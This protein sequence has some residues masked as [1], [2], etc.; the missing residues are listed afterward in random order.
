[1][2]IH[3]TTRFTQW[4]ALRVLERVGTGAKRIGFH[5]CAV[6]PTLWLGAGRIYAGS[7]RRVVFVCVRVVFVCARVVF[8]ICVC[9]RVRARACVRTCVRAACV[10][11][12]CARACV[13]AYV[14]ACV[15]VCV[16]A[17]VRACVCLCVC[18]ARRGKG[19]PDHEGHHHLF[20]P[21]VNLFHQTLLQK[22]DVG[23]AVLRFVLERNFDCEAA[24][25]RTATIRA[26]RTDFAGSG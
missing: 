9:A 20:V 19:R 13:R 22:G 2:R 16:R 4:R 23:V 21:R 26:K 7:R 10:R 11:A 25:I 14:R 3:T 18:G 5:R 8:L 12:A 17:C 15:R 6:P 24:G 1:V